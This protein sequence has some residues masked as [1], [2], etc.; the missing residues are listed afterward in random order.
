MKDSRLKLNRNLKQIVDL[1]KSGYAILDNIY[2]N[3]PN[4][5]QRPV[6]SAPIGLSDHK[7]VVCIPYTSLNCKAPV[8][9]K[10]PSRSYKPRD[11]ARFVVAF[12]N[13]FPSPKLRRATEFLQFYYKNIF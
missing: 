9:S 13:I 12:Q 5:Y 6:I 1:P 10:T 2:N 8:V 3:V 11:R 4:F 7:V